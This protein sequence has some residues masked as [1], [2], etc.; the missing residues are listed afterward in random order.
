MTIAA[1]LILATLSGIGWALADALRK[2]LASQLSALELAVSLHWAQLPFIGAL[3]VAGT[4]IDPAHPLTTI[5]SWHVEGPYWLAAAPTIACNA[6]ANLLFVRALQLSDLSLT[7]PY[8]SLTPV[9]A[10]AT[11]WLFVGEIPSTLGIAGVFVVGF[12]AL[13]LN[14]GSSHHGLLGPLKALK[15]ERGSLAM[16]GVACLWS[17]SVAFDK[18]ALSHSSALTHTTILALSGGLILEIVRRRTSQTSL[19]TQIS[20]VRGLLLATTGIIT[21]ALVVQLSAYQYIPIAYVEAVKRSLGLLGSVLLGWW[22]FKEG[23]L[24][25][26]LAGVVVMAMGVGL[27]LL[28]P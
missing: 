14:P 1:G 28:N 12:G 27:I 19:I 17:I 4:W 20:S 24:R 7:I 25:Q 18:R 26:R 6:A 3:L 23:S 5:V 16:L 8:L 22:V 10:L 2:R 13:V 11:G 15:S 21:L 9:L